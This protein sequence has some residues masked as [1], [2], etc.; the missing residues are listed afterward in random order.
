MRWILLLAALLALAVTLWV[1]AAPG[2]AS[3][4]EE[5]ADPAEAAAAAAR[6]AGDPAWTRLKTGTRHVRVLARDGTVPLGTQVG[7]AT[8]QGPRL[9][10]VDGEG[11]RTLGD[12][13]LGDV[14]VLVRAPGR[15]PLERRT[16][17]EAGVVAEMRFE[18]PPAA[19]A[20]E[21]PARR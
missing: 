19:A 10:Y 16:R 15:D 7:F 18:L 5:P 9:Y 20:A 14:T 6:E 13:P 8:P 11:L 17:V 12:I 4:P 1:L 3:P 21:G 2:P